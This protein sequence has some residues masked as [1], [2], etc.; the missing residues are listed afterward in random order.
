MLSAQKPF[1]KSTAVGAKHALPLRKKAPFQMVFKCEY[2]SRSELAL[3][4]PIA[5]DM[6]G[7]AQ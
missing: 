4:E 6:T 1:E 2:W 3:M 7:S 5:Q